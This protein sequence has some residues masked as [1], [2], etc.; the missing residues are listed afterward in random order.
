MQSLLVI[1]NRSDPHADEVIRRCKSRNTPVFRVNTEDF[2][3]KFSASLLADSD[4]NWRVNFSGPGA[5]QVAISPQWS[6]W[7][8]RPKLVGTHPETGVDAFIRSEL[9]ALFENI[10]ALPGIRFV[11]EYFQAERARAK[12]PQLL[13]AAELGVKVPKTL[14]TTSPEAAEA[15]ALGIGEYLLVK[16]VQTGNIERNGVQQGLP[17]RRVSVES[18]LPLI[19]LV[20]NS[21]VQ[22]Q[23]YVRK[24]YELRVT[25]IGDAVFTVR[26]DSQLDPR[27]EV[28]WRPYTKLSP[29]KAVRTPK[30]LQSFCT[31]FLHR[32]GLHYGAFDFI[33]TPDDEY[34]F[35]ENNPSGQY[36]WLE[37]E[38]SVPITDALVD[39]LTSPTS[40][41]SGAA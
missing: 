33:V 34:V 5:R 3:T 23:E 9:R 24:S 13:L 18:F 8:R 40:K 22:L 36:L 29:H 26:I 6:V 19:R 10:Y 7:I 14:I 37:R 11:N 12:F 21:P 16:A 31:R 25:V 1:T 15:F 41:V 2:L 28:D 38:T 20:A 35:L 17:A 39:F 4:G 27:T 32:Q 30:I